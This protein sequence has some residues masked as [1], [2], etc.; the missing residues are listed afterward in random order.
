MQDRINQP[1]DMFI[2]EMLSNEEVT[3]EL[4]AKHV[5]QEITQHLDLD[6]LEAKSES[7]TDELNRVFTD[8][9]IKLHLKDRPEREAE[10]YILIEHKSRPE[11]FARLQILKYKLRKWLEAF[12]ATETPQYLP[13]I[14]S[15]V[16]THG[17]RKWYYSPDFA[18]LFDCPSDYFRQFIPNFRHLLHDLND[19]D[20]EQLKEQTLL[21]VAQLA[22]KFFHSN[23]LK[24]HLGD[25]Y[26]PLALI[27]DPEKQKLFTI[28]VTLYL[29][30][31]ETHVDMEDIL[32]VITNFD[33]KEDIVQT[34]TKKIRAEERAISLREGEQKGKLE[35]A[36]TMLLNF[37][38]SK[39]EYVPVGFSQKI[40]AIEDID[41]LHSLSHSLPR[42][43]SLEAFES[44]VDKATKPTTH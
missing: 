11:K 38:S 20:K 4:I 24:N 40:H 15:M 31:D 35:A 22:M 26:N 33:Q 44:L 43:E 3:R 19:L 42:A 13:I 5:P 16:F 32:E 25:I 1:H 29:M 28:L 39:F 7:Y 18:D 10:I 21:N 17:E 8:I 12:K 36:R 14:I 2:V 41:V 23:E 37:A 34:V 6:N 30:S 9:V 27:K